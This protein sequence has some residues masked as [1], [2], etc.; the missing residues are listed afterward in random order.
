MSKGITTGMSIDDRLVTINTFA[1]S[2]GKPE[3]LSQPGH[4]FPLKAS[5]NLLQDRQGHTEG[6]IELLKLAEL[7]EVGVIIEMMD[8]QGQMIK[9]PEL[10]NLEKF[11]ICLLFLLIK[12]KMQFITRA[13]NSFSINHTNLSTVIENNDN[14]LLDEITIKICQQI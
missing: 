5:K 1:S 3:D 8:L 14:K 6:T 12:L 13:Y 10:K 9:G 2:D 7:T 4:L 11:I